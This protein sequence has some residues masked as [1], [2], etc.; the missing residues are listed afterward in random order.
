MGYTAH[1]LVYCIPQP[2]YI[3]DAGISFAYA[4]N[5]VDGEGLATYPGG[6]RVEGYSNPTWT[7]LIAFFYALGFP[8]FT[9]SK[10]LGWVFGVA[11]LPLVWALARRALPARAESPIHRDTLALI[12][13]I[14]VAFNVQ[15]VV[16]NAAGLENSLVSC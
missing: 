6:E 8:A 12:A 9:T 13:P 4:Q 15:F 14:L 1:Y 16:W 11:T 5:L 3:E 7:F 10:V 2:F